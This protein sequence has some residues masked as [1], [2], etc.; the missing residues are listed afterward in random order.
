ML[1]GIERKGEK[2]P[3]SS[4]SPQQKKTGESND[5]SSTHLSR[6]IFLRPRHRYRKK[7]AEFFPSSLN[8]RPDESFFLII[9]TIPTRY[10]RHRVPS[11]AL[12]GGHWHDAVQSTARWAVICTSILELT[13]GV[14][15]AVWRPFTIPAFNSI[16]AFGSIHQVL[17]MGWLCLFQN[18]IPNNRCCG[19]SQMSQI[20]FQ[21]HFCLPLLHHTHSLQNSLF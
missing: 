7:K 4:K 12:S 18:H 15:F 20:T 14:Y 8:D 16:S 19:V 11:T 17:Q 9:F 3:I 13:Q 2:K 21:A 10:T 6:S 1:R 5:A